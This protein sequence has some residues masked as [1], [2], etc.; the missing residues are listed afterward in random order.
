TGGSL[1]GGCGRDAAPTEET[2]ER[3]THR[4]APRKTMVPTTTTRSER[5][6]LSGR[7]GIPLP[8]QLQPLVAPQFEHLWHAPERTMIEPHSWPVG[9]S[10]SATQTCLSSD[11]PVGASAAAAP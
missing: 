1:S 8:Y 10:V 11:L 9:A 5:H 4:A 3:V 2:A 7:R 6:A